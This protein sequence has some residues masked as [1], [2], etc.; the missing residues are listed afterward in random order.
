MTFIGIIATNKDFEYITKKQ[1]NDKISYWLI[2]EKSIPNLKNI[3]FETIIINKKIEQLSNYKNY[4]K[5]MVKKAKYLI[6]NSDLKSK[7]EILGEIPCKVI[8][9]GLNQKATITASSITETNIIACVQ[10][11]IE[12]VN[13]NIKEI[14][15]YNIKVPKVN[16]NI[17]YNVLANVAINQLYDL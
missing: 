15:E 17:I 4:I 10:R 5:N 7:I 3:T 9:Y 13:G 14:A 8:T 1:R 12:S 16:H 2:N 6:I 11:E